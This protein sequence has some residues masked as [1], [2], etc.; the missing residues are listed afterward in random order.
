MLRGGWR[1]N[2]K[3]NT[4]C[5]EQRKRYVGYIHMCEASFSYE[6]ISTFTSCKQRHDCAVTIQFLWNKAES[7]K[8]SFISLLDIKITKLDLMV[9]KIELFM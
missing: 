6:L 9:K 1:T 3:C 7:F 4:F 8:K 5:G 2:R